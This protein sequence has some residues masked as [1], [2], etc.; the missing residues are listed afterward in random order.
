MLSVRGVTKRFGGITALDHVDFDLRPGEIHALLGENG[1]GKSTL[2]KV[3]GG[4]H[5]PDAG[6]THIDGRPAAIRCVADANR[7]GIRLIHQELSL[8][9]NLTVAENIY[10]GR[11]P[12]RLGWL[13]PGRMRREARELVAR[14]GL[15]E[16]CRVDAAVSDLTVAHQQLV[17]IARALSCQVRVLVLDEPTSSLS[18]A[19]TEALFVTLRREFPAP[20]F[21]HGGERRRS[22]RIGR[23]AGARG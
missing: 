18:E 5:V 1:A 10:M 15:H 2:I 4:I 16:L 19:E 13:Q 20:G 11:E 17:E 6:S 7:R 14:L 9:P 23:V 12:R 8:A 21:Y 3:L 22:R